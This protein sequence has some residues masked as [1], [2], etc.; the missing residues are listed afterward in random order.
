MPSDLLWEFPPLPPFAEHLGIRIVSESALEV[1]LEMT[2]T[3]DHINRNGVLHGG[4]L[5]ALAD[6]SGGTAAFHH[7]KAG[8]STTTTESKTNFFRAVTLGDTVRP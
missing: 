7:L 3:A 8:E 2:V 6:N 1:V 4:A 5:M